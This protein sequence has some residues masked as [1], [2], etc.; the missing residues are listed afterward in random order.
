[1]TE[2]AE[3]LQAMI[4]FD[5]LPCGSERKPHVPLHF[6][7]WLIRHARLEGVSMDDFNVC[8]RCHAPHPFEVHG[9]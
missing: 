5:R 7:A 4:E 1:M 8:A 2:F 9:D 6:P 3:A